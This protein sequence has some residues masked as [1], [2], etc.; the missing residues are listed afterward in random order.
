MAGFLIYFVLMTNSP[1]PPLKV[2]KYVSIENASC[3]VGP[4]LVYTNNKRLIDSP[5]NPT[6][7]Y[8][9]D[10]RTPGTFC[11]VNIFTEVMNLPVGSYTALTFTLMGT[12]I[13]P[14]VRVGRETVETFKKQ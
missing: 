2:P 13:P 14:N 10:E 11:V 1:E 5:F 9:F 8:V 7:L 4:P 6:L 3:G 12:T